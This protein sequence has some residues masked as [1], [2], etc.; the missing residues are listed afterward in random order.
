VWESL[1]WFVRLAIEIVAGA[2]VVGAALACLLGV[3]WLF[4]TVSNAIRTRAGDFALR[5][6]SKHRRALGYDD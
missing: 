1:P 2:I 4:G 6:Q 3:L 5:R